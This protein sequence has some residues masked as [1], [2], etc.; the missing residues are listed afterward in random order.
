MA[1]VEEK[2]SEAKL[3]MEVKLT[4]NH[5]KRHIY[6]AMVSISAAFSA[7]LTFDRLVV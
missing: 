6:A 3:L 1:T 7:F 2:L 4:I 5:Q